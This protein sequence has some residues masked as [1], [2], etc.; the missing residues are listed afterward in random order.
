MVGYDGGRIAAEGLA[1]HVV[2]SR[3][4]H[5][6]RIQEAQASAYH[7]L[8]ELVECAAASSGAAEPGADEHGGRQRPP[9][10]RPRRGHRPGRRLPALRAP[11]RDVAGPRRLHP[12][13]RARRADRGR[14]RPSRRRG[15]PR[16][17]RGPRRRRWPA[18][19]GV[20][21][22]PLAA[23][24]RARLRDRAEPRRAAFRATQISPDMATCEDCLAELVD[25]GDRRY[26]YPFINCTNCGPRFTIVAG[27]PYDR[28][29]TTM[30]RFQ[31][32]AACRAEYEDPD[33]PPLPRPAERLPR[34]RAGG[35]AA[36]LPP[37]RSCPAPAAMPSPPR[38]RRW[39][40][41]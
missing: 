24:W 26:R 37:G 22:E 18:S 17:A 32:C 31:M 40:R 12:Q 28:P 16:A 39:S 27:I 9:A 34:L 3:S 30:A 23:A 14:G 29:L 13:R 41:G 19:S 25:P 33:R 10:Q 20:T 6:P 11:A 36:R 1:D 4:Q 7:L 21:S 2:I 38:P 5:I 35:A 15:V 8:R